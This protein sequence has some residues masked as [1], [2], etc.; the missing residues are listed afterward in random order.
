MAQMTVRRIDDA[1]YELLRERAR[2]HGTS[3]EALARE[4]IHQAAQLT[5]EE[6]LQIV[7]EMHSHFEAARIPGAPQT[8]GL[9]LIREGRDE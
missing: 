8:L 3:V 6:K 7:R 1:R 9:D 5:V 2:L 4:A